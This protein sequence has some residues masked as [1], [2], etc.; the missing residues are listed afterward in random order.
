MTGEA[1]NGR[2]GE[3]APA[4]NTTRGI[5]DHLRAGGR[6]AE[7]LPL[8]RHLL[9]KE[10]WSEEV[11]DALR[12]CCRRLAL[13][14]AAEYERIVAARP[15]L[16][17]LR[18]R[19]LEEYR[20]ERNHTRIL[21]LAQAAPKP[22]PV[23][24]DGFA[25][26]AALSLGRDDLAR[27]LFGVVLAS[28]PA[29]DDARRGLALLEGRARR[30]DLV[31]EA[32]EGD[33]DEQTS[34]DLQRIHLSISA[35]RRLGRTM[36]SVT[37]AAK[38]LSRLMEAGD[39]L[40]A[41]RLLDRFGFF[42]SG[43]VVRD[44]VIAG[45]DPE[46]RRLRRRAAGHLLSEGRISDAMRIYRRGGDR[47]WL[48]QV[49]ASQA[50]RFRRVSDAFGRGDADAWLHLGDQPLVLPGHA[51]ARLLTLSGRVRPYEPRGRG[52]VLVSGTLGAGGAERQLVKTA[53]GLVQQDRG[54]ADVT[55]ATLQDMDRP[56]YDIFGNDLR[57]GGVRVEELHRVRGETAPADLPISL[58]PAAPLLELLNPNLA[59]PLVSLLCLFS[60][61]RPAVVHGWQ[62]ATGAM[63]ALAALWAGVPRIVIG[64]RSLAPDR[65]EGRNRPWLR[66][67]MM[68]L[69]SHPRV[70]ILN[71]SLA[72][73]R[74]YAR[75][76]GV[77][78]ARLRHLPNG[79]DF[80]SMAHGG[81]IPE[82]G[83]D[84]VVIGG[85]MRMTEEKRPG[86]WLD[87][88]IEL[89]RA[90]SRVRGLL[91]GEG[92]MSDDLARRLAA[93]GMSDRIVLAG[94][95]NDMWAQYAA[96]D[97]LLLTSRTEGLPNV[98]I[99]AQ[100]FGCPVAATRSGGTA[101]TFIDGETGLLLNEADAASIAESLGPL[102]RGAELRYRFGR[103]AAAFVRQEFGID[104][105]I[106]RTL[107]L[108][109]W[110][111]EEGRAA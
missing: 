48:R 100:A 76:L 83:A 73:R 36:D 40:A 3:A 34:P 24:I 9:E 35:Q 32:L 46:S 99:E 82:R 38:G 104:I 70:T 91:V 105:M 64:T 19:L 98:L 4:A 6:Y 90:D 5:A 43:A 16:A 109:G 87:T 55:V 80:E 96:M 97:L 63:A 72:G 42:R 31:L 2:G 108:Y 11:A 65:K 93:S 23:A 102:V 47:R 28:D 84:R 110:S 78:V 12:L 71:N 22:R 95:R 86:L 51:L 21:E 79:Y 13:S 25:A 85:V 15:D 75:W 33:D 7:A 106:R 101:E 111:E 45:D 60:E 68:T 30:F 18:L 88:V 74:D 69:A 103:R 61:R 37:T 81:G 57:A 89:C 26:Q 67:A 39:D 50:Q 17:E 94:R 27:E 14:P 59:E 92:P 53:L 107:A 1:D 54:G 20:R 77:P 44:R 52:V 66:E 10:A 49:P 58:A 62:D 41:A 56:G 29:D 8:Y